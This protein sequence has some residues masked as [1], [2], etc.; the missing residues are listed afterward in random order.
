MVRFAHNVIE[1]RRAEESDAR[2]VWHWRNDSVTRANFRNNEIVSWPTH[3]DWYLEAI[4]DPSRIMLIGEH[5]CIPF[6]IV[7][8]DMSIAGAEISINVAPEWRGQ[9]LGCKL[10]GLACRHT[11]KPIFAQIRATNRAS[12]NIFVLNGFKYLSNAGEFIWYCRD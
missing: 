10:L 5:E 12:I 7:R 8:L 4:K 6:G 11:D 1:L 3:R 9:G 2:L